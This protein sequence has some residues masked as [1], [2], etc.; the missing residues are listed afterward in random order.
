VALAN[1]PV[2]FGTFPVFDVWGVND[3]PTLLLGMDALGMLSEM[4]IDYPRRQLHI[5][6]LA[7]G[8]TRTSMAGVP[9]AGQGASASQ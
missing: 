3:R 4:I 5:A 6:K 1:L 2:S 8:E 7:P 9:I